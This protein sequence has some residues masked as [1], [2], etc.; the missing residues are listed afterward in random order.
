LS[1]TG[2]LASVQRLILTSLLYTAPAAAPA[3]LA[4]AAESP[5]WCS[6]PRKVL[7]AE[8][9]L[10]SAEVV[11]GEKTGICDH[12]F[13]SPSVGRG[14]FMAEISGQGRHLDST[15]D[16][17]EFFPGQG[18][19]S[20]LADIAKFG[21][22]ATVLGGCGFDPRPASTSLSIV[23]AQGETASL[24]CAFGRDVVPGD[25]DPHDVSETALRAA[26]RHLLRRALSIM[27]PATEVD[28]IVSDMKACIDSSEC[29]DAEDAA[30]WLCARLLDSTAFAVY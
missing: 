20:R 14:E 9:W 26:A 5:P 29:D 17:E 18:I 23:S 11:V 4:G 21:N 3:G 6:G 7:V 24:L 12:R 19:A 1:E 10:E 25:L 2:D 27:P 8:S 30:R 15:I 16:F 28:A 13:I 22:L